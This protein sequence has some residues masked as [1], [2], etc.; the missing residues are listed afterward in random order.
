MIVPVVSTYGYCSPG[1]FSSVTVVSAHEP[2]PPARCGEAVGEQAPSAHASAADGIAAE[3]VFIR[4][5]SMVVSACHVRGHG[6]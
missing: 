2:C 5:S 1:R 6:A 3:A 4:D